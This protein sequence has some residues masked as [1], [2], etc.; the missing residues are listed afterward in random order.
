MRPAS[1]Q[2]I[3]DEDWHDEQVDQQE[4]SGGSDQFPLTLL[5]GMTLFHS[6]TTTKWAKGLNEL[7]PEP[8]AQIN[9][10]DAKDLQ[11]ADGDRVRIA[12]P[13]GQVEALA[14]VTP[15]IRKGAVFVPAHYSSMSVSSLIA[16][17]PVREKT[18]TYISV[19]K[20]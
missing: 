10:S 12:S 7:S 14:R 6:G 15:V 9:P 1:R 2:Q 17:D 8:Q 16:H 3:P 5:S 20:V 19:S 4:I 11:I 13:K 18:V